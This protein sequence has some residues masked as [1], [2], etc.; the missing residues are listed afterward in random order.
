MMAAAIP[1]ITTTA[2]V[3]SNRGDVSGYLVLTSLGGVAAFVLVLVL[4]R[5]IVYDLETLSLIGRIAGVG[6]TDER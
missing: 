5:R 2:L 4:F 3:A 6:G 1:M